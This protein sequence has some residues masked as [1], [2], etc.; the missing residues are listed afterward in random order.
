M[1]FLKLILELL[2]RLLTV[3]IGPATYD[4]PENKHSNYDWYI[5]TKKIN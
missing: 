2:L 4:A 1:V 3:V 5:N